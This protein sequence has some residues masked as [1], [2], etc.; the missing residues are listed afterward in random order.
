[1]STDR[2]AFAHAHDTFS[3]TFSDD[4]RAV[5]IPD[6][7]CADAATDSGADAAA[8]PATP[9]PTLLPLPAPTLLPSPAPTPLP[10]SAPSSLPHCDPYSDSLADDDDADAHDARPVAVADHAAVACADGAADHVI[11]RP[12]PR[13]ARRA[14]RRRGLGRRLGH[15]V[16]RLQRHGLQ[17]RARLA[18][19][20]IV[21]RAPSAPTS[22]AARQV[23]NEA[24][25]SL[26][27]S[28]TLWRETTHG[29]S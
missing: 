27:D 25:V 21:Q 4:V 24:T 23:D 13:R 5:T 10:S 6:D 14:S 15:R 9:A 11:A 18:P 7:A 29:H 1:M 28:A 22:R 3:D 2:A 12:R 8:D 19:Q 26:I 17:P 20:R 16:R